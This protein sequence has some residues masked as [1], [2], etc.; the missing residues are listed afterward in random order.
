MPSA[1]P[2]RFFALI[3]AVIALLAAPAP[4][5]SQATA[6]MK[7][8]IS[9]H[10]GDKITVKTSDGSEHV[11]TI[12]PS[13]RVVE[14]FGRFNL[15][16]KDMTS[17][18][19]LEGLAVNVE[20]AVNGDTMDATKVSFRDDDFKTAQQINVGTQ[21]AKK[22]VK[23]K[24]AEL[25]AKDAEMKKRL[26]EATEYVQKGQG[27][28]L[29]A[30]GSTAINAEGKATIQRLCNQAQSIKGYFIGVSGHADTT[31]DAR[32]NQILSENRANAVIRYIQ[33][34]CQIQPQRVLP[35]VAVGDVKPGGDESTAEG[36]AQSRRVV[37]QIL[38]NKGLE[39]L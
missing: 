27:T 11:F 30:T 38:V 4:A 7:G 28:V 24:A 36:R 20:G 34:S 35:G 32:K 9:L 2:L 12:T 18:D 31:G 3:A 29:F 5:L 33:R 39:G 8:V 16:S 25:E 14:V 10:E 6:P 1:L 19:L 15:Q 26:S 21:E 17:A 22:R 23:A 37:V 13:T